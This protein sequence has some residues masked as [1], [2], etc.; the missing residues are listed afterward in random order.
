MTQPLPNSYWVL[1]KRLL[2]GEHPWGDN[3][4]DTK[5]RL[6]RL[7]EAGIN[8][9]IDLTEAGETPDYRPLLPAQSHYLRCAIRDME[10]PQEVAQMQELLMRIRTALTLGRRIYIHCRAGIGRTGTVVGCYLAEG[11][12]D[13]ESALNSLNRLWR[14]CERAKS[15]PT[16]PQTDEQADF[17]RGWP[18]HRH[19]AKKNALPERRRRPP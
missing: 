10:V 16:V 3:E 4:A 17:I 12:L 18:R 15:W 2:A 1:P 13:G 11:G 14:L 8:Y 5:D 9:F 7:H 6:Q 19:T